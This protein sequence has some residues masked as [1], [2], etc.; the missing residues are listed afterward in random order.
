MTL[1]LRRCCCCAKAPLSDSQLFAALSDQAACQ[2]R[3]YTYGH[4]WMLDV[5]PGRL[6]CCSKVEGTASMTNKDQFVLILSVDQAADRGALLPLLPPS[7]GEGHIL[8]LRD[9]GPPPVDRLGAHESLIDWAGL[10]AALRRMLAKLKEMRG[11]RSAEYHIAGHAPLPL[12]ALLGHLL[13]PWAGPQTFYNRAPDGPWHVIPFGQ[14]TDPSA[15]AATP[16]FDSAPDPRMRPTP[17]GGI[18]ALYLSTLGTA[19]DPRSIE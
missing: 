15:S 17:A 6:G 18:A 9:F 3:P 5:L 13:Q 10:S 2:W 19:S 8:D 12:F 1:T 11:D 4:H 7:S 14:A 16:F